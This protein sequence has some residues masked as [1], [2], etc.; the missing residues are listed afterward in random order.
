MAYQFIAAAYLDDI[1]SNAAHR[2]NTTLAGDFEVTTSDTIEY[3]LRSNAFAKYPASEVGS[4]RVTRPGGG[5][6]EAFIAI[7]DVYEKIDDLSESVF[8]ALD[9]QIEVIWD[10]DAVAL[11]DA[12]PGDID[13]YFSARVDSDRFNTFTDALNEVTGH[14]SSKIGDALREPIEGLG[15]YERLIDALR[16]CANV[17]VEQVAAD[18]FEDA[19]RYIADRVNE[20]SE[21]PM[22]PRLR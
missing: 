1:V 9:G 10:D 6:A 4:N 15:R 16:F 12:Y 14:D 2:G 11:Y 3:E 21:A 20:A 22:H 17:F 19:I 8:E 18:T 7:M 5:D 13:D